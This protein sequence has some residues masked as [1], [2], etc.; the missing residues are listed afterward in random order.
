VK[1]LHALV[2]WAMCVLVGVVMVAVAA[3][4]ST[5][6]SSDTTEPVVKALEKHSVYVEQDARAVL[7]E[8]AA[9]R[10]IGDR[11]LLVAVLSARQADSTVS[12]CDEIVAE[13]SRAL[14]L[15]YAGTAGPTVCAGVYHNTP[16]R[17][18]PAE[19]AEYIL[20]SADFARDATGAP[21]D[22][23]TELTEFVRA[24]DI[25]ASADLPGGPAPRHEKHTPGAWGDLF[26]ALGGMAGG[27]VILFLCA[28]VAFWRFR[29]YRDAWRERRVAR[30]ERLAQV[31]R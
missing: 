19:W 20:L 10:I 15:V 9:R 2:A 12:L 5:E 3:A 13:Y 21:D 17:D 24:Y 29:D 16:L 6:W 14:A 8:E 31:R 11:N 1:K 18:R 30:A 26:E 27:V 7:D 23:G 25:A 28:V 22:I 4:P